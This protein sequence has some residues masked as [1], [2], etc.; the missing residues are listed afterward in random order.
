[1]GPLLSAADAD[2]ARG[3]RNICIAV[4]AILAMYWMCNL[5]VMLVRLPLRLEIRGQDS[6]IL[7]NEFARAA[8]YI[9]CALGGLG[10]ICRK[11][12]SCIPLI[13]GAF[14]VSLFALGLFSIRSLEQHLIAPF[15]LLFGITVTMALLH[16]IALGLLCCDMIF[17]KRFRRLE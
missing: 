17:R 7:V 12:L 10:L 13:L 3:L 14:H 15:W 6:Y 16:A 2:V 9:M 1:M 5:G 4:G 11:T 8:Y